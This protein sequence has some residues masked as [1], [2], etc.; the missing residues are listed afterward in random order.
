MLDPRTG[1]L[2]YLRALQEKLRADKSARRES[3]FADRI[4]NEHI[5]RDLMTGQPRALGMIMRSNVRAAEEGKPLV[6][7]AI[8]QGL[9]NNV[10]AGQNAAVAMTQNQIAGQDRRHAA[11]MAMLGAQ[12]QQQ[13]EQAERSTPQGLAAQGLAA[14]QKIL[15]QPPELRLPAMQSYYEQVEGMSADE[16]KKA[17]L[18]ASAVVEAQKGNVHHPHVAEVLRN[19]S[20]DDMVAWLMQNV[21]HSD[22]RP[23][24]QPEAMT[25]ANQYL[26]AVYR[27]LTGVYDAF[28]SR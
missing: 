6:M 1:T 24:S 14:R 9:G 28:N 7:A 8:N 15:S 11:G 19:K 10:A 16:A 17:A 5:G 2:E 21:R 27:G 13:A 3:A 23:L 4:A 12:M 26:S 25:R 20:R 22:G 18:E